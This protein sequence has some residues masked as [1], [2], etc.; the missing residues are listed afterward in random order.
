MIFLPFKV[1]PSMF[2][3]NLY[4]TRMMKFLF[5]YRISANSFRGTYSFLNLTLCTYRCGNYSRAETIRGNTVLTFQCNFT[6]QICEIA[7][8]SI[9]ARTLDSY[10][11]C[12]HRDP[13][14]IEEPF[15]PFLL[16]WCIRGNSA[17]PECIEPWSRAWR[18]LRRKREPVGANQIWHP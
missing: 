18:A 12:L 2:E 4:F 6:L 10:L 13:W 16:G 14:A 1:S 15:Q 9:F 11:T 7:W 5:T 3:I 17:S 8:N